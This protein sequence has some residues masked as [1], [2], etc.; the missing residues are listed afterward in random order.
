[1][2]ASPAAGCG[3][4][5]RASETPTRMTIWA[6]STAMH[7]DDLRRE[8]H[9]PAE[10]RGA[11]TFQDAIAAFEGGGDPEADHRRGHDRER[12]HA[13]SEEVHT[14]RGCPLAATGTRVKKTRSTTGMPS[15]TSNVSPR[16]SVI[17]VSAPICARSALRAHARL[18]PRRPRR[19]DPGPPSTRRPSAAA[20]GPV[21][22][23]EDVLEPLASG[24][25]VAEGEVP[26]RQPGRESGDESGSR[27]GR[28]RDTRRAGLRVTGHAES[29][30]ELTDREPRLRS[31][32]KLFRP[33]LDL[34]LTSRGDDLA[35]IDDHH[36]VRQTLHLVELVAR[37]DHA[38][39]RRPQA[40][41]D[42]AH[43]DPAGRVDSGGRLVEEGDAGFGRRE[44]APARAAAARRRRDACTAC[45]ATDRRPTRSSSSSGSRG[46]S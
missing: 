29:R 30:G 20:S 16:S 22:P 2:T 35:M 9:G 37:E 10:W 31:K 43:G 40:G 13:G 46:S 18:R 15:V 45:R 41:D 42:V 3:R 11:E 4:Q 26:L 27:R 24:A 23:E 19:S 33:T 25:E 1:M 12:E 36:P 6:T 44:R 17:R 7:R 14:V 21:K 32:T 38:Y 8:Q 34:P 39:T 28:R 5:P